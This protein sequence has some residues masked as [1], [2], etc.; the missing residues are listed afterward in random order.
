MEGVV[1]VNRGS[2][3]L[4]VERAM[5]QTLRTVE[6]EGQSQCFGDTHLF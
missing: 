5:R 4:P 2:A 6:S 1:V 3:R